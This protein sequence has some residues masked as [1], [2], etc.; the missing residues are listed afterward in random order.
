MF[1]LHHDYHVEMAIIRVLALLRA[2]VSSLRQA[3]RLQIERPKLRVDATW[4]AHALNER[5]LGGASCNG[6]LG[7]PAVAS[8][9][10]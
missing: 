5:H 6:E 1:Y 3:V 10:G 4:S 9:V 8:L 7:S 2:F